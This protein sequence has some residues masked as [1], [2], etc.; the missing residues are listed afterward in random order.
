ME[1]PRSNRPISVWQ[2][3]ETCE[4]SASI[5]RQIRLVQLIQQLGTAEY[6]AEAM[7]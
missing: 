1:R 2:Q 5:S 6:T 4:A 3:D 7:A